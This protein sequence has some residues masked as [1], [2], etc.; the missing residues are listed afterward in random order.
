MVVAPPKFVHPK[1]CEL[2]WCAGDG[3]THK[4]QKAKSGAEQKR[5]FDSAVPDYGSAQEGADQEV[6]DESECFL[7]GFEEPDNA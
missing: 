6:G 3:P 5:Y 4:G 2:Q 7:K 1:P